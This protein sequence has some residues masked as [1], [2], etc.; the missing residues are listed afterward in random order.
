MTFS[1]YKTACVRE[2]HAAVA[3]QDKTPLLDWLQSKTATVDGIKEIVVEPP[4]HS[5]NEVE[6]KTQEPPSAISRVEP[7]PPPLETDRGESESS[8]VM[9]L[10]VSTRSAIDTAPTIE[11]ERIRTLDSVI[12]CPYDF[13]EMKI[14]SEMHDFKDKGKERTRVEA[15]SNRGIEEGDDSFIHGRPVSV[16]SRYQNY[17]ILVS[18]AVVGRINNKN[19]DHFL[20]SGEW[21]PPTLDEKLVHFVMSHRHSLTLHTIKY[22]IVADERS[23][24]RDDWNKVVAIFLTGKKWQIKT[25][26]P[27]DPPSLFAKTLGIYVGWD[28]ET[29]PREIA[30]WRVKEFKIN[31]VKRHGDPQVVQNIW[32]EIEDATS[33]L[34]KRRNE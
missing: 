11:Y 1:D 12:I 30:D 21:L 26:V 18:R 15:L 3:F 32:H 27:N 24:L 34:K 9:N 22:D 7:P 2:K 31:N 6:I 5:V 10:P 14:R 17:I 33:S 16:Q 8:Y 28:N 25:Y 23:L 20:N 4:Q 13:A 29:L 19:I